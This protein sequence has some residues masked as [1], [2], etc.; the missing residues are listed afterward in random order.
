MYILLPS[1]QLGGGPN[2]SSAYPR[3]Q[4]QVAR[5]FWV[6]VLLLGYLSKS[7]CAWAVIVL[8]L[9]RGQFG[10]PPVLHAYRPLSKSRGWVLWA[11]LGLFALTFIPAPER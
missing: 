8:V 2:L 5:L 11:C 1:A 3:A 7:S 10:H 6:L 4:R 9:S